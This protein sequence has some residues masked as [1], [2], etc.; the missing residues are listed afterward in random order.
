MTGMSRAFSLEGK[1]A[2]VT[3]AR[4]GIGQAIAVGLAEAGADLLLLGHQN[5][6][7]ETEARIK[8]LGGRF[9]TLHLDLSNT[10]ELSEKAAEIA[11]HFQVDIL[12][13][14]AGII[15]RE[16]AAQHSLENWQAVIDTNLNSMFILTQQLA[17]PM[18]ARRNGKIINI[19]SL[20]SFQGGINV[21]GY[22]AAK[23][24]VTGLTKA[25]ANEWAP[26]GVQVNAIAPGYISTNNTEALRNDEERSTSILSRIPAGRWGSPSDLAGAAVFLASP[27]ADYVN[28]HVLVVDGGW[29]AR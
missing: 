4:T 9:D 19:A 11:S 5:N 8:E 28:G 6:M 15:R 29:M 21:P 7:Q 1:T 16:P 25:L 13:N 10:K 14:N 2:L 24:A 22:T 27:A 3:G 26:Y 17:K 12:V 23:H 20:L 18:L